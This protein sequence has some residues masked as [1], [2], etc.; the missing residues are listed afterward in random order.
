MAELHVMSVKYLAPASD[1]GLI[2][3]SIK[4]TQLKNKT[5]GRITKEKNIAALSQWNLSVRAFSH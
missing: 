2:F 1:T 3:T 4:F 5:K